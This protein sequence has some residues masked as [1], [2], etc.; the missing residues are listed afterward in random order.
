M[1]PGSA[2]ASCDVLVTGPSG[3]G[4][5]F[6]ARSLYELGYA[7]YDADEIEGLADWYGALGQK[8]GQ[9][10]KLDATFLGAHRYLWSE[11][12][13]VAWL[14]AHRVAVVFG[15]SHNSRD[16]ANRF[17][18]VALLEVPVDAVLGNLARLSR[19]NAFGREEAHRA[20]A[21]RDTEDY[22]RNAPHDWL[23][24]NTRDPAQLIARLEYT[25]GRSLFRAPGWF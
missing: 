13:L 19:T 24:L 9:P 18:L 10:G 2:R 11:K 4:K 22:Y 3:S 25:T 23:R 20:M 6:F 5:S 1:G 8:V 12:V 17:G 21:R 15:I 7:T 16:L 14:D